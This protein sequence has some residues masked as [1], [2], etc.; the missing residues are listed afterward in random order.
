MQL[1]NVWTQQASS[2]VENFEIIHIQIHIH[3][4]KSWLTVRSQ[5]TTQ[6]IEARN[7]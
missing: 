1:V 7:E 4:R 5:L 2:Y 6:T 3:Q